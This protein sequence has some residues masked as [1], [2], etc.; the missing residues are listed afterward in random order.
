[1]KSDQGFDT[2]VRES[3]AADEKPA[4]KTSRKKFPETKKPDKN[5]AFE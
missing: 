1:M 5:Q 2:D 4:G 3:Y